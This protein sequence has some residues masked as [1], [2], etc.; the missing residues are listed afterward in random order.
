MDQDKQKLLMDIEGLK[1][2]FNNGEI[3]QDKYE[4]LLKLYDNKLKTLNATLKI[5][6]IQGLTKCSDFKHEK[7][8]DE[9]KLNHGKRYN[10]DEHI[11]KHNDN[12]K[13]KNNEKPK[14]SKKYI[15]ITASFLILAFIAGV[16]SGFFN[17]SQQVNP[18][19][20]SSKSAV[21]DSLQISENAF[22]PIIEDKSYTPTTTYSH[23]YSSSYYNDENYGDQNNV[24]E[25]EESKSKEDTG[26]FNPPIEGETGST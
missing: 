4:S 20:M 14:N 21:V 19:E 24:P 1:Q 12:E 25:H 7:K 3:S 18:Q 6:K 23:Q 22:P 13:S 11:V 16:T 17:Y 26:D 9:L 5:R 8:D 15:V 2:D 10:A